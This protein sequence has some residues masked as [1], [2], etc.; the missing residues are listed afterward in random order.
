MKNL[1]EQIATA[2]GLRTLE[3]IDDKLNPTLFYF[4]D[5]DDFYILICSAYNT[6]LHCLGVEE[7][8]NKL[9]YGINAYL[10]TI[11]GY[12]Q[13]KAFGSIID[14][15]LSSI[16]VVELSTLE[17]ENTLKNIHKIEENYKIAKK[18]ILPYVSCDFEKLTSETDDAAYENLPEKLN[19][20]ALQNSAF[21]NNREESW[22]Q[23]LMNLFIKLPFLNYQS[24]S[25]GLTTI[26]NL[27]EEGLS[28]QEK[29]LLEIINDN[30]EV[31]MDVE[32]FVAQ[33]QIDTDE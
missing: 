33:F 10:D 14:F 18:Y 3:L 23:L 1:I 16:I 26:S 27:F 28:D 6:L 25:F 20:L 13:V 15:N 8:M 4:E 31:N 32:S 24:G 12:E 2:S 21:I 9:D 19:S 5:R 7:D 22:Y 29:S 30:Y 11:K 17:D